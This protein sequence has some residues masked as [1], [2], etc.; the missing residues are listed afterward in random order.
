MLNREQKKKL[1]SDLAAELSDSRGIVFS[2]FEGLATKD[3]QGLRGEL[4]RENIKHKVVKLSLLKRALRRIGVDSEKLGVRLPLAISWSQEDEVA[5]AKILST[6]AKT[7][8]KLKIVAGVLEKQLLDAMQVKNLASLPG[9][10]ELRAQVVG[11][12][13]SSLRGL[14]SVL[15][16]N[17]RGL[18]NALNAIKDSKSV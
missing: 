2:S 14:V 11:V 15:A 9:K 17:L 16:G 5:P 1:V 6:F 7:H 4:R 12:I 3:I 10:Q 18:V 8:D 13:A